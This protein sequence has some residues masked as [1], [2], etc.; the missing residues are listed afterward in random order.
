MFSKVLGLFTSYMRSYQW[1]LLKWGPSL[2]ITPLHYHILSSGQ[3]SV[4]NKVLPGCTHIMQSLNYFNEDFTIFRFYNKRSCEWDLMKL[5]F[6][7]TSIFTCNWGPSCNW[8]STHL[9]AVSGACHSIL[10]GHPWPCLKLSPASFFP[11]S[12]KKLIKQRNV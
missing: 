5:R 2:E 9:L 3:S 10:Q 8:K 7:R 6:T 4:N 11:Y 12:I 1:D